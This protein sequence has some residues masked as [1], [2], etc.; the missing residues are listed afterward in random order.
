L[1]SK[2]GSGN[3]SVLVAVIVGTTGATIGA[4][5]GATGA[6]AA[7]VLAAFARKDELEEAWESGASGPR[8]IMEM[9]SHA[10]KVFEI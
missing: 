6:G 1:P 4:G 7:F 10:T 8:I 2:S 5:G 9:M 3:E